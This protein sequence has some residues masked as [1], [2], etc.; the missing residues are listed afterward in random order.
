MGRVMIRCPQ[1]GRAIATDIETDAVTFSRAAVF[2]G[3]T[4]CPH[5][6][7]EHQWFAAEAWVHEGGVNRP[8]VAPRAGR[9]SRIPTMAAVER[10]LKPSRIPS[11]PDSDKNVVGMV[12]ITCPTHGHKVS[13]GIAI[14]G[15]RWN[16]DAEFIAHTGCPACGGT[17]EW[18][19]HDV[20]L[21]DAT[22]PHNKDDRDRVPA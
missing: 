6:R 3:R 8:H 10:D 9:P 16:S 1:S 14:R 4:F 18:S 17:H 21:A 11:Q 2:F 19:V 20:A 5:C 12:M 22:G 13:T 15:L 7:K